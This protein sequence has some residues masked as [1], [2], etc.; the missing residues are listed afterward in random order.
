VRQI[1][2]LLNEMSDSGVI[3]DYALFGAL[4]QMRYTEA[5]ATLDADVLIEVEATGRLDLLQAVYS[6][7]AQ[8]GFQPEGEA[9]R[10][11]VW[12]V[13]FVPTFD[14]ITREAVETAENADFDGVPFRV[15]RPDYLAVIALGVGRSKGHARILALLESGTVG[16]EEIASLALKYGLEAKWLAF[17]RRF[18]DE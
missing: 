3:R 18:L 13:Q 15:V 5:V 17:S 4:A 12:P 7:C 6:Y 11:G 2:L 1:A 14:V 8:R 16:C 10:V 9:I